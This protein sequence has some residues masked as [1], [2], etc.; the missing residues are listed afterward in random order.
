MKRNIGRTDQIVRVI[1]GLLIGAAGVYFKSWLGLFG[2][3]PIITAFTKTC[4]LYMPFGINTY[5]KKKE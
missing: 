3:I 4:G 5:R 2:I 1:L